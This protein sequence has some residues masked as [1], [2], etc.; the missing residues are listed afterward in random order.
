MLR[1]CSL[2]SCWSF[3]FFFLFFFFKSILGKHSLQVTTSSCKY[4]GILMTLAPHSLFT[5][6]LRGFTAVGRLLCK[7][8]KRKLLNLFMWIR[9]HGEP[10]L[11][12]FSSCVCLGIVPLFFVSFFTVFI[13]N[14]SLILTWTLSSVICFSVS[15]FSL[16]SVL[17]VIPLLSNAL[18]LF[19]LCFLSY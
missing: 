12:L 6:L 13:S 19:P 2:N 9:Q 15:Y 4:I 10:L 3:C 16:F 5:S 17:F 1:R 11:H 8:N 18:Y 7:E 14:I